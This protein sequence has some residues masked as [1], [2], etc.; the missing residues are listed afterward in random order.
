MRYRTGRTIG[1]A[2]LLAAALAG[3]APPSHEE[4]ARLRRDVAIQQARLDLAAGEGFYL[5]LDPTNARLRL[6]FAG[7]ILEEYPVLGMDLGVSRRAFVRG[8]PP[9][10]W[11]GRIW[12]GG[13]LA[14]ARTLAVVPPEGIDLEAWVPPTPE[15][16]YPA[17]GRYR[18]RYEGGLALEIGGGEQT[19]LGSLGQRLGDCARLLLGLS[20]D[21]VRIRLRLDPA[22]AASLYRGLPEPTRLLILPPA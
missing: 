3:A 5:L 7:A 11:T 13:R 8:E 19:L 14:P 18:V 16:A 21:R 1:A 15:E 17:P 4:V 10:G 22:Q 12:A 2:V 9:A 6:M 20:P